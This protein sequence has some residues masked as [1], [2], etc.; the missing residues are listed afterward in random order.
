[1]EP[2]EKLELQGITRRF[3][4][5]TALANFNLDIP[6]GTFVTLLGP[7]GCGKTTV[8]NCLAGLLALSEGQILLNHRPIQDVPAEKRGFGMVFQNYALF[9][10]LN[11]FRNVSYG[12]E[13]RGVSKAEREKRVRR[14]L[15]QVH[16]DAFETRFPA[17][18][19]GGQQQ[20]LAFA[21]A[22]VLE[23]KLVLLDEPLSN[24]DANLRNEMRI[25]IKRLHEELHLTTLYV[26]HDQSEA[27]SMSDRVVVMRQGSIEQVDTPQKIYTRPESLFVAHFMG[28]ANRLPVTILER[29]N[30]QFVVQTASGVTL[31]ATTTYEESRNWQAGQQVIASFRPDETLANENTLPNQMQ[32]KV[33]LVEYIGKAFEAV[34]RL[35]GGEETQLLVHSQHSIENGASIRFSILPERL[36]LFPPSA[37]SVATMPS[38]RMVEVAPL[39]GGV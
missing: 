38:P 18:L 9:P 11:V 28:Y 3:G 31:R 20:R 4:A 8:L 10:H 25:E 14:A 19:S 34:V 13:I 33:R 30:E 1:M 37:E 6:G 17:Q 35:E 39:Q 29:S 36:L 16:L 24:L 7:S 5:T 2:I 27:L 15:A 12:L 23:P 26:T 21:R 22:I 32:G